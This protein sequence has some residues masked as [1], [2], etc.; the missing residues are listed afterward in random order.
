MSREKPS[1]WAVLPASVRYDPALPPNAKLLYAEISSLADRAGYCF[2]SNEYFASNFEL[3][4][5]SV[6][7]LIKALADLKYITVDVIRDPESKAVVERRIYVGLNPAKHLA[8]PSPQ[9]R[10][11]PPQKQGD[12]SPQKRGIEQSNGFNNNPPA[13]KGG[14]RRRKAPREAPDWKPERFAGFWDFY[15]KRGRKDKQRAMDAWDTLAPSDDLIA[16]IARALVRQKA[17]EEWQRGIG[18]PYAATYLNGARWEDAAEPDD[19]DDPPRAS[20]WAADEEVI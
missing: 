20:G 19:P 8:P 6:Q 16:T 12:P 15:P 9:K 14:R 7:R 4:I 3:G 10:G 1:Y 11:D 13:P 2:A 18:I 17:T 5:K